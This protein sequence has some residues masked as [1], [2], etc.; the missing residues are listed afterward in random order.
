MREHNSARTKSEPDYRKFANALPIIIWICDSNGGLEWVNDRWMELTGMSLGQSLTGK[1]ALTAVHPEDRE[2]LQRAFGQALATQAPCEME[3]RIR[4]RKGDYRLHVCRVAPEHTEEGLITRWVAAA[5]DIHDRRLTEEALRASERRFETVFHLNPQPTA[6]TRLADG[7]FLNVNDA[8]LKLTGYSRAEVIGKSTVSLGIWTQKQRDAIVAPL[9]LAASAEVEVSFRAKDGRALTLLIASARIDFGG[10]LCLVNVAA[11]ATERLSTEAALRHNESLARARADELTALM[12]AVPAA[13]LISQDP[14]CREVR[15]NRTGAELL[16]SDTRKNLSKGAANP[17]AAGHF[18]VF[19]GDV[20]IPPEELPLQRAARGVE[21]RNHEEQIHFVD[22]QVI[23]LYGSAVPLRDPNGKPRGA[24]GAFVDVTRLKQAEAAM[25]LADRRKDEFLALLSHELRNPLAPIITAAQLMQLRGDIATPREREVILRQAQHLVRLVDDLLDVSR[26]ARGKVT[27]NR[28]PLEL[29]VVVARAVEVIGPL[30]EQRQHHLVLSA[31][32]EGLLVEADEVRLTQII[33]NLLTNAARYTPP[34]GRVEV[35]A[36][37]EDDKIVLRV[38]D[39]GMGIDPELLPH[40]F[41]MFVQGARGPD[42]AEGG[43]GL[44]LSLVRTLVE[45]HGGA[46]AAHSDGPGCG[47]EFTVR[48]PVSAPDAGS[49]PAP[50]DAPQWHSAGAR[51]RRILVVDDNPD[52]AEMISCILS[53][54]GHD[55]QVANDP[56]Q[57][58]SMATTFRPQVA[59]LDIGLPVMDGYT[60]ARELRPRLSE[61]EPVLIALTGYGHEQDRQRSD[62]AGFTLHLVKPVDVETLVQA[63]DDLDAGTP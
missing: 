17:A 48:L 44:G 60:L 8:F 57:A 16:R 55:V 59:I 23:H 2:Q 63:I 21:V 25:R 4:T 29:G 45:L 11:D 30:L 24:I 35:S 36:L 12:D 52:A 47:S 7:V 49:M 14:A 39:N 50:V 13:V 28:K 51:S 32:A 53:V 3:Y 27:L 10:E 41:D 61:P 26:V 62:E 1:G 40:L 15:A 20:E 58:L 54:A 19:S 37:R 18:K 22:G 5:F 34:G 38:R 43:L 9:R 31:P 56:S 42:R 6:I 33:S 46:V